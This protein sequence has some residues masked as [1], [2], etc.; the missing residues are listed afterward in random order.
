[1]GQEFQ[2]VYYSDEEANC[3]NIV[4]IRPNL[5]LVDPKFMVENINSAR[6]QKQVR[7]LKHGSMQ[8]VLNTKSIENLDVGIPSLPEQQKIAEFLSTVNKSWLRGKN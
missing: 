5:K 2:Y 7:R 4:I 3:S 6:V 1:M 8:V